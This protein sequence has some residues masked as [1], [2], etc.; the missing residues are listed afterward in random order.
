MA[1][2]PRPR[3]GTHARHG[4]DADVW[5]RKW[6]PRGGV[7]GGG[8]ERGGG[9]KPMEARPAVWP[10]VSTSASRPARGT[11]PGRL[12]DGSGRR[13]VEVWGVQGET[14]VDEGCGLGGSEE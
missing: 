1:A 9:W 5:F 3:R 4:L 8:R 12:E 10:L 13:S 2:R 11:Y 7:R 6:A 14:G